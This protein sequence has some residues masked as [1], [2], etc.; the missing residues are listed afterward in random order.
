MEEPVE[1]IVQ[2]L[3]SIAET[4]S[5]A[6]EGTATHSET[7][8]HEARSTG[9]LSEA[10]WVAV[11]FVLFCILFFKKVLPPILNALDTRSAKIASELSQATELKNEA[12]KLLAEAQKK[13]AETLRAA[14]E[15]IS[16]AQSEAKRIAAKAEADINEE[17]ERKLAIVEKKIQR[18]EQQAIESVKKEAVEEATRLA[19]KI[20]S[21]KS[22]KTHKELLTESIAKIT[23][24]IN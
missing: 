11:A 23:S 13:S 14:Q 3:D 10:D 20:L 22:A 21:E 16:N 9:P 19:T 5:E 2:E 12:Q 15:M 8:S 1:T 24:S 17:A 6:I 7:A 4:T 18:A